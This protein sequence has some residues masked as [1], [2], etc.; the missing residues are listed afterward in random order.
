MD[1]KIIIK[2]TKKYNK[3][4]EIAKNLSDYFDKNGLKKIEKDLPKQ[5][6]YGIFK[7][8]ELIGFASYEKINSE[9][10]EL[11]WMAVNRNFQNKGFGTKL[12]KE[13]ISNLGKKYKFCKVKTLAETYKDYGFKKTRNFYKKLGFVSLEIIQPFPGWKKNNPCQIF[14]K[15]LK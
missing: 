11:A 2:K 5:L 7:D 4:L 6:V 12:V 9:V 1:S 3:A 10:V 15:Y 14:V 13:S 8:N